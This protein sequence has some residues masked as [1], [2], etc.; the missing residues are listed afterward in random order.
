ML[1]FIKSLWD[2]HPRVYRLFA[3]PS[4]VTIWVLIA[5][6]QVTGHSGSRFYVLSLTL[7]IA[8]VATSMFF[9]GKAFFR[10]DI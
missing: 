3:A 5:F 10:N 2:A 6:M 4:I 8:L 1:D 9:I 7:F